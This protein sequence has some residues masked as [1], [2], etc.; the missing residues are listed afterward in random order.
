LHILASQTAEQF[1]F[2]IWDL[3]SGK[4]LGKIA[5]KPRGTNPET[6]EVARL[7]HA[8]SGRVLVVEDKSARVVDLASG[9]AVGSPWKH[10]GSIWFARFSHDGT[11]AITAAR[12]DGVAKVRDLASGKDTTLSLA[13]GWKPLDAAFQE[14][15]EVA[16]AFY[17]GAVNR[18]RLSTG[19]PVANSL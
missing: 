19:Q 5:T 10:E 6:D 13:Y 18:Y 2:R 8:A 4:H 16:V 7:V 12:T 14:G 3:R 9:K 17:D 1:V 15:G 11:R